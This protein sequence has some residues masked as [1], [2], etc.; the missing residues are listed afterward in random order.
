MA[1][2]NRPPLAPRYGESAIDS[3]TYQSQDL[4]TPQLPTYSAAQIYEPQSQPYSQHW[5]PSTYEGAQHQHPQI[6]H[7]PPPTDATHSTSYSASGGN[8]AYPPIPNTS[9]CPV[10]AP[11]DYSQVVLQDHLSALS[12]NKSGAKIVYEARL[13]R[14]PKRSNDRSAAKAS[15]MFGTCLFLDAAKGGVQGEVAITHPWAPQPL[16]WDPEQQN[17]ASDIGILGG[18]WMQWHYGDVPAIGNAARP[19]PGMGSMWKNWSF[20]RCLTTGENEA[21]QRGI[22]GENVEMCR[23]V[24]NDYENESLPVRALVELPARY[25]GP[26]S[27]SSQEQTDE[28][29]VNALV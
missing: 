9:H 22:H 6:P 20:L 16:N 26:G 23:V 17:W 13:V 10:S 8:F 1:Q 14:E 29:V 3:W 19:P 12:L 2:Y 25:F 18:D 4:H 7:V 11:P 28:M 21:G 5:Q 15:L 27:G 24:L